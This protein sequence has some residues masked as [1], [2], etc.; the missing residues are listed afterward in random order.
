MEEKITENVPE[1]SS[2]TETPTDEPESPIDAEAL[3][4]ENDRFWHTIERYA[5]QIFDILSEH[6]ETEL[7]A[8]VAQRLSTDR[9]NQDLTPIEDQTVNEPIQ[10]LANEAAKHFLDSLFGSQGGSA[11]EVHPE[12]SAD[13]QREAGRMEEYTR[14]QS[15]RR[16]TVER[17]SA[18]RREP[19][20]TLDSRAKEIAHAFGISE[21]K[22]AQA[23]YERL[24]RKGV[25]RP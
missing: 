15:V 14:Q 2:L 8:T 21:S 9:N 3:K 11:T 10:Q 13:E 4:A 24:R 6:G 22:L 12:D 25:V 1:S 20:I 7:L 16:N 19:T 18:E 23:A 5:P 17:G